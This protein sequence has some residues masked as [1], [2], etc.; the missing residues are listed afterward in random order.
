[1]KVI[2]IVY[3]RHQKR[4]VAALRFVE[5]QIPRYAFK[6]RGC[7]IFEEAARRCRI[8]RVTALRSYQERVDSRLKR[9]LVFDV[10]GV[11]RIYA[12]TA[13]IVEQREYMVGN[14]GLRK[15]RIDC[16]RKLVFLQV[17]QQ[18]GHPEP[19]GM[20]HK[21]HVAALRFS[22]TRSPVD[23]GLVV[24][25]LDLVHMAP[26]VL[27]LHCQ[28]RP[29]VNAPGNA[30]IHPPIRRYQH[31][32]PCGKGQ[33]PRPKVS[34]DLQPGPDVDIAGNHE[35]QKYSTDTQRLAPDIKYRKQG[36]R[37]RQIFEQVHNVD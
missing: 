15:E 34:H 28:F 37:Y 11:D 3:Y 30:N 35:R 24:D 8:S 36:C 31:N 16:L 19:D 2:R 20:P 32:K 6:Q 12:H 25:T 22:A 29:P 13:L 21:R 18:H 17:V 14:P 27:D 4:K 9:L 1:M 10:H 23:V 26:A 5:L 33:R 7:R